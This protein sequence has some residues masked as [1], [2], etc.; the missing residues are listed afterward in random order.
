MAAD[1]PLS[2]LRPNDTMSNHVKRKA[3][4]GEPAKVGRLFGGF[5]V[6]AD[7]KSIRITGEICT[8]DGTCIP[9][10]ELEGIPA[11]EWDDLSQEA[12]DALDAAIALVRADY[13][14]AAFPA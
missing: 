13:E 1:G 14:S 11:L 5:D 10:D 8:A 4:T 6:S 2:N 9:A 12:S 7:T 3:T